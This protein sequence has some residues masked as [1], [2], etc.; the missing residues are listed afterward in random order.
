[1]TWA[2]SDFLVATI[3]SSGLASGVN[4]GTTTIT[5]SLNGVMGGTALTVETSTPTETS[6]ATSGSPSTYGD[7]V[8]FTA[9]VTPNTATGM[10]DFYDGA[11][12]LGS[13]ALSGD[14]VKTAVLAT[15]PTQFSAGTKSILATY[16]GNDTHFS[17]ISSE[18]IQTVNPRPVQLTGTRPYNGTNRVFASELVIANN[19]DGGNLLLTGEAMLAGANAGDRPILAAD[20]R[21]AFRWRRAR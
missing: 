10:V 4:A 15:T 13:V 12:L 20:C 17:S 11:T 3:N 2:T 8:T 9:T 14:A 6:L 1:V 16:N 18:L 7:I 19:L 5:A 21:C